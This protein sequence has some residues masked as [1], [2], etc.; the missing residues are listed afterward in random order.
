MLY[1]DLSRLSLVCPTGMPGTNQAESSGSNDPPPP[2]P[3]P[4]APA[5]RAAAAEALKTPDILR[6]ILFDLVNGE[7]EDACTAAAH[8]CFLN[9]THRGVCDDVVWKELTRMIFPNVRA[10]NSGSIGRGKEPAEPKDWFFHLCTQ[11]KKLRKLMDE[12]LELARKGLNA[13][14][15]DATK[16]YLGVGFNEYLEHVVDR[17]W[18]DYVRKQLKSI[19]NPAAFEPLISLPDEIRAA[20]DEEVDAYKGQIESFDEQLERLLAGGPKMPFRYYSGI[21]EQNYLRHMRFLDRQMTYVNDLE[22]DPE[23][24]PPTQAE[25]QH[26]AIE[27]YRSRLRE[28]E[29]KEDKD[30]NPLLYRK[31]EYREWLA[32]QERMWRREAA[33]SERIEQA[34]ALISRAAQPKYSGKAGRLSGRVNVTIARILKNRKEF[35]S[36]ASSPE[37]MKP[38]VEEL[39]RYVRLL[40]DALGD[41]GA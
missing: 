39:E 30:R 26:K 3:Q 24:G 2:P 9:K 14:M 13:Q 5:A 1:P 20:M 22:V 27:K 37:I 8:W 38:L 35:H 18:V 25:L 11:H 17:A 41:D 36:I 33:L 32:E 12:E 10:P 29:I 28:R 31:G 15:D 16:E 34:K 6:T 7:I 23:F 21:P 19:L 4:L 40:E